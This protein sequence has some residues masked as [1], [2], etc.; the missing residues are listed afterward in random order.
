MTIP[1]TPPFFLFLFFPPRGVR[2]F[3]NQWLRPHASLFLTKWAKGGGK[4]ARRARWKRSSGSK[5]AQQQQQGGRRRGLPARTDAESCGRAAACSAA[6]SK[7]RQS[8]WHRLL[9]APRPHP[10]DTTSMLIHAQGVMAAAEV[11]DEH[12]GALGTVGSGAMSGRRSDDRIP[13]SD[14]LWTE[15]VTLAECA[16]TQKCMCARPCVRACVGG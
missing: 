4:R 11:P 6:A 13:L 1:S 9:P 3:S 15:C 16:R 5:R 7:C 10:A 12:A 2:Q 8:R 14:A